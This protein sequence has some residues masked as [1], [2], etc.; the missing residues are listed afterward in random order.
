MLGNPTAK[1]M[2]RKYLTNSKIALATLVCTL[3]TPKYCRDA[4]A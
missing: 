2:V 1:N 4:H 3:L